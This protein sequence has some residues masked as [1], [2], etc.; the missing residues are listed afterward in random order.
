MVKES[1]SKPIMESTSKL[2]LNNDNYAVEHRYETII[3][4]NQE[5][6]LLHRLFQELS[7]QAQEQTPLI[8]HIE[9]HVDSIIENLQ[10]SNGELEKTIIERKESNALKCFILLWSIVVAIVVGF[11]VFLFVV[12][13]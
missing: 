8:H 11:F 10:S 3:S 12:G 6:E 5:L 9:D 4:I 7:C 2:Q 1:D 13:N